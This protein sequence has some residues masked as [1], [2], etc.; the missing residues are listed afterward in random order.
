MAAEPE[1]PASQRL[2]LNA[3]AAR[4]RLGKLDAS[5]FTALINALVDNGFYHDAFLGILYPTEYREDLIKAAE[6]SL[7]CLGISVPDSKGGAVLVL[8]NIATDQMLASGQEPLRVLE[9]L[10]TDLDWSDAFVAACGLEELNDVYW[11]YDALCATSQEPS[12]KSLSK[13]EVQCRAAAANWRTQ[14][15]LP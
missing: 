6:A 1:I 11:E 13:L 15:I 5:D 12:K 4:L 3:Q 8:T 2:L 10:W 14:N 7:R 9:S